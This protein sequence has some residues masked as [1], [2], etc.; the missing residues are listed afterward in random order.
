M[1][2]F[3]LTTL[4]AIGSC[5]CR[6]GYN[7]NFIWPFEHIWTYDKT[8]LRAHVR[9]G[10]HTLCGS[11]AQLLQAAHVGGKAGIELPSPP[12]LTLTRR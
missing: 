7:K 8:H 2:S 6:R 3:G 10:R 5:S 4:S 9:V 12:D 1:F 11:S